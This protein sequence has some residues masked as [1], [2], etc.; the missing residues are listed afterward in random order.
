LP[1]VTDHSE[2][3]LRN[4]KFYERIDGQK[5]V[6]SE[7][8]MTIIFYAAVHKVQACLEQMGRNPRDHAARQMELRAAG[9]KSAADTYLQ[10][11]N[12]SRDARYQCHRYTQQNLASY[13]ELARRTLQSQL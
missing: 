11:Y 7:W 12:A 10:L 4:W 5:A 1:S 2:Q 8:A 6:Y 3:E 9:K 13:E